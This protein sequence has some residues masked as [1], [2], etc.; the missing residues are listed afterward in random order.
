MVGNI[1]ATE[2]PKFWL[3][4]SRPSNFGEHL[5]VKT[6][7]DNW[8]DENRAWNEENK[9]YE[10]RRTQIYMLQGFIL[11]FFTVGIKGVVSVVYHQMITRVRYIRD[12]YKEL[13][14]SDLPPGEV[15]QTSWNGE[16][17]FIRRLTP[18]EVR[19]HEAATPN[20]ILDHESKPFLSVA[21]AGNSTI[22][23]C[24][25][26]CTH[27]GCIPVP[28]LGAYKGWV[29]LCHGSV[30]D[31]YGRVRQGPA[32]RNLPGINNAE[33]SGILCIEEMVFPNEPSLTYYV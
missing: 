18:S 21:T 15:L 30:F 4:S 31:K 20:Q 10:I 19:D 23:V 13:D 9:D 12:S 6:K 32:L 24:S 29:C 27:L 28:Y 11:S 8:F 2:E 5:D 25:A 17:I 16:L 1:L 26:V 33:Y 3:T 22:L 14:I 7:V